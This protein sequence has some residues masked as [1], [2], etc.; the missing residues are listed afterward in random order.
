M[1]VAVG[2]EFLLGLAIALFLN[3]NVRGVGVMVVIL[4]LPVLLTP[5]LSSAM[6][7]YMFS[8][9][10]GVMYYYLTAL[11]LSTDAAALLGYFPGAFVI[12]LINDIWEW[13]PFVALAFVYGLTT[14]PTEPIEAARVDGASHLQIFRYLTL[15]MMRTFLLIIVILRLIDSFKIFDIIYPLT[16]GGPGISTR[17]FSFSIY[18]QAFQYLDLGTAAAMSVIMLVIVSVM[19]Q[20]YVRIVYKGEQI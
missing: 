12:L 9:L 4:C 11:G 5:A 13:T 15:P 2:I 19:A 17:T 6:F 16:F 10:G 8:S 18:L 7:K 3:R 1:F 20:I 14:L